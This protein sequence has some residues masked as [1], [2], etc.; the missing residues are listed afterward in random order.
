MK[1]SAKFS[2]A[3]VLLSVVTFSEIASA[4]TSVVLPRDTYYQVFTAGVPVEL[5]VDGDGDTD[6]D[7]YVY[8]ENGNLIDSDEDGSDTCLAIWTPR[9]TGTFRI[10]VRNFG[11]VSNVYQIWTE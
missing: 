7:L 2:I 9:W 4:T 6:L 10:E 5:W 1:L 3:A 11:Y 8:D